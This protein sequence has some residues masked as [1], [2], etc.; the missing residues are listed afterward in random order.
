[1]T[2]LR[3]LI[4]AALVC[5][6]TLLLGGSGGATAAPTYTCFGQPA[7][8]VGTPGDD[9]LYGSG[10]TADVIV[11]LGGNDSIRGSTRSTRTL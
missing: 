11:G 4:A 2:R 3:I 1:M 6:S 9:V 10:D 5:S 7:T 8:I